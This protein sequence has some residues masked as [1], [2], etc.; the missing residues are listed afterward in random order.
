MAKPAKKVP[1]APAG[2]KTIVQNRRARRDFHVIDRFETG[3]ELQGT[4]VK[5]LRAG[6][7]TL[8]DSYAEV[9]NGQ[10]YLVGAHINPYEQGNIYNHEPDRTRRLLMHKREILRI[11]SVIAERGLTLVPLRL[12]FKR[13]RVKVE[14]GL[15]RGKH[16]VDKRD[17]IRERDIDRDT[18]RAL[19]QVPRH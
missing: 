4:E 14:L 6:H 18:E 8:T 11:G 9:L 10:L 1:D 7:M 12:Y 17:A 19:R 2:E 16:S 5:S 3:I 15:C 13:G